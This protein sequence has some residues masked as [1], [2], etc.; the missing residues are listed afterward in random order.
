MCTGRLPAWDAWE[1]AAGASSSPERK[2]SSRAPV[3]GG[4][5]L[6]ILL[7]FL[8]R[9]AV[10]RAKV[11]P[12]LTATR[13]TADFQ[14]WKG[15]VWISTDNFDLTPAYSSFS[16]DLINGSFQTPSVRVGAHNAQAGGGITLGGT[17]PVE[18]Y[19]NS[20]FTLDGHAIFN[21]TRSEDGDLFPACQ[22]AAPCLKLGASLTR[23]YHKD[24]YQAS[25]TTS[26]G[27]SPVVVTRRSTGALG[28][29]E[30]DFNVNARYDDR[31]TA[32]SGF[33]TKSVYNKDLSAVAARV[34]AFP[35]LG[36][37]ASLMELFPDFSTGLT[38]KNYSF[39]RLSPHLSYSYTTFELS[40]PANALTAGFDLKLGRGSLAASYTL[41]VQSG[42]PGLPTDQNYYSLGGKYP[43]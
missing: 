27:R 13:G 26:A 32:L 30:T 25:T 15:D 1:G 9:P 16:N 18:G 33:V 38:L 17:L 28:I 40:N 4:V 37:L 24:E 2:P 31:E 8:L 11:E 20:F 14:G 19:S 6:G 41:Y 39:S 10:V 42:I 5:F 36:G 23:I 22:G 3:S 43:F 29:N 35:A 7:P 12:S 34:F 21:P